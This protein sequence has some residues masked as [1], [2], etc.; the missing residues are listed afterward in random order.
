MQ[1]FRDA[2]TKARQDKFKHG[3]NAH[4]AER[5]KEAEARLEKTRNDAYQAVEDRRCDMLTRME[6]EELR[7]K[8]LNDD[9]EAERL[10]KQEEENNLLQS[11]IERAKQLSL[12]G[13]EEK[14][15]KTQSE[16]NYKE[17]LAKQELEKVRVAQEKR[18][19]I[20]QLRQEAYILAATRAKK[21]DDYKMSRLNQEIKNKDDRSHA[22]Q[23]GYKTLS[24]MRNTMK[25]IVNRATLCLKDEIHHLHH[26]DDAS[27]EKVMS[28]AVSVADS[29]L[30]PHLKQKFGIADKLN[31]STLRMLTESDGGRATTA[32]TTRQSL[33]DTAVSR[34]GTQHGKKGHGSSG[35]RSTKGTLPLQVLTKDSLLGTLK[36]A[37][38]KIAD[39]EEK[40]EVLKNTPKVSL[41]KKKS[42]KGSRSSSPVTTATSVPVAASPVK[43]IPVVMERS[44]KTPKTSGIN[45]THGSHYVPNGDEELF[46][47]YNYSV[48]AHGDDYD[49]DRDLN[50]I[51]K[52]AIFT[53]EPGLNEFRR[54]FSSDHPLAPGGKGSYDEEK[55]S[56]KKG[57]N[58]SFGASEAEMLKNKTEQ[59][60]E[61]LTY[62]SQ[63]K[64][65]D[66]K[67]QLEIMKKE[68]NEALLRV[69]ED[70]RFAEETR[71]KMLRTVTEDERRKLELIFAEER[72][73]ASERIISLTKEHEARIKDAVITMMSLGKAKKSKAQ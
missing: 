48:S 11:K 33:D 39:E 1:A 55:R 30:F 4:K 69:L 27:P 15:N 35:S 67:R 34:P 21:M 25:D 26:K 56:G 70:E 51:S 53:R 7:R 16:L 17:Q 46:P 3:K 32:P 20:K 28:R 36:D 43:S 71:E 29:M 2:E 52:K 63:A 31:E 37:K 9:R 10:R 45:T 6:A 54:E 5:Q 57:I 62:E 40:E 14:S 19:A 12:G 66:P 13:A 61:R 73:R 72:R 18:R 22:I 8:R 50:L 58:N 42:K 24:K 49:D 64:I 68:Q 38:I 60:I 41:M 47:Q 23:E 44:A 59:K 65:V